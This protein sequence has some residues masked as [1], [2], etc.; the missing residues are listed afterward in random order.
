M[1]TPL[2]L[3]IVED[4]EDD[5]ALLLREL[6]RA[7]HEIGHRR[8]DTAAGLA[9]ALD[10]QEW[11]VILAD[12]TMP[13]FS[14]TE[15]LS[16]VRSRGLDTPFL[17]VSGSMGE[18]IAVAAMK[19]GAQDYLVK[20]NLGRLVPA[21]ER[22]LREARVRRERAQAEA[23]RR[24]ADARF[25]QI[26][27][28]A[29]D[30]IIA[31][32]EDQRITLFNRGAE[33]LFEYE[34]AEVMGR[35]LDLLLP[36]RFVAAHRRHVE[37]FA[38]SSESSKPMNLRGKVFGRRKSG[39]EF[40]AEASIAKLV[41]SGGMTFTVILRDITERERSGEKLRQLSRAVEQSANFVVITD[42]HGTIE[43]VNPKFLEATGY[44]VEE[45]VGRN[46]SLWKSGKTSDGEY[47]TLWKTVTMGQEWRGEFENRRKDGSLISVS[48]TISP[49]RDDNGR[50]THF[51]GIQEDITQRRE[52]EAQLRRSQKLEAI[53]QLTGGLAHDFNNLLTVIIGN[54]EYLAG[55][56]APGTKARHL[57]GQALEAGLRGADLTRQLL[58]FARRQSL[59]PKEFALNDLVSG[60][61]HLLRRTLGEQVE[62]EMKLSTDLWPVLADPT[63]VESALANLAINARDAMPGGGRLIIETANTHLDERYAAENVEV[64][65]GDYVMLAVSDTGTGIPPG[66]LGRV[67]E[68][69]FTTKPQGKGTGLGLSMVYG[70]AKQSRGHVKIYSEVGH[71]TTVRLY[72]PRAG[73]GPVVSATGAPV[74][75]DDAVPDATILVV[76][77]NAEVRDV[78]VR[79]LTELGY[80]VVEA[81]DGPSALGILRQGRPIDLLFTDMVMPG[82]MTGA[83]LAREAQSLRPGLKVLLTSG[84]AEASVQGG[85]PSGGKRNLLSKPY[86]KRDLARRVG[87]ILRGDG[88]TR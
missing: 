31:A 41:E 2:R 56:L 14:G 20:G 79:Q 72:L 3:L 36:A 77:D 26:L 47:A 5:T 24:L 51:V 30:A 61:T 53:G 83:D 35:P 44:A 18:D 23:A 15:A 49:V 58:A 50:I 6:R 73:S 22:E 62:V 27:T 33:A 32:D 88:E 75:S 65:P 42:A 57:A 64:E 66:V 78:T 34:A 7:G 43:Y 4:S 1:R 9:A 63:Q 82:G 52:I 8:V 45:V 28:M 46:P 80:R 21:V 54:L 37:E 59:E 86:R 25:R 40:P 71:G 39:E 12:Y 10:T 16:I 29:A 81:N 38:R 68:P 67:F 70:F 11:D 19:A 84:F 48:A 17:F 76:E 69:F 74:A 13:R 60:I 85:L 55:E 87:E